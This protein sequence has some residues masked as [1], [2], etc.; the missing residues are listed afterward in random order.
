[1]K[2][3]LIISVLFITAHVFSQTTKLKPGFD[4]AEYAELLSLSYYGNS[5]ADS[6]KRKTQKDRY[7]LVYRSQE[8]G[9][10][11]RWQ[12]F[13]R[14]DKVAVIEIRGTVNEL[15]SWLENF[16]A[17][18]IPAAGSLQINDSTEFNYKLA[19]DPK[20]MVHTGWTIGVAYLAPEI[21]A[22][23]N[24]QYN[25][26]GITDFL[27]IGH[28]QG[29]ALSF[30]MRSYLEYQ[31]KEN[32]IPAAV[33]FKTYCSAAPKPGNLY[34]AYDFDFITRG[35]WA[36]TI[37]NSADWVPETP[38]SVQTLKDFNDINPFASIKNILKKQKLIIRVGGNIV[39]DKI[40]RKT[41]KAQKKFE[42]YL[43]RVVYKQV[44]NSLPQLKEPNYTSGNNYM[45]AGNPVVLLADEAYY[46]E[47]TGSKEM[48]FIHHG[49]RPYYY[50]LNKYY[51]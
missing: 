40:D 17:A 43:G 13:L 46:R 20:A 21:V 28:S 44:K 9:L 36:Y 37:V 42:K 48:F 49:F 23:I 3:L 27:M 35:G 12:L 15:P 22:A 10:L 34:Y 24:K 2:W 29:G 19:E 38:F 51:L 6:I 4:P 47:F 45:R 16:Y 1:M 39:Y 26:K 30:L 33:H 8:T 31:K 41:R 14:D 5:I 7:Q 25:E 50:L 11:N 32:K 18:M